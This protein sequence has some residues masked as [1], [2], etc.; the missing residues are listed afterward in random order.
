ML[1]SINYTITD[2]N[3]ECPLDDLELLVTG[4]FDCG[5]L[6]D[7][8]VTPEVELTDRQHSFIEEA[9]VDEFNAGS[10]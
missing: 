6:V 8:T 9:L 4:D 2:P 10:K 1:V 5:Q 7:Y 3:E